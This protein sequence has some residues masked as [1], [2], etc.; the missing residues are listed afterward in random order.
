[1]SV[2]VDQKAGRLLAEGRVRLERVAGDLVV[3]TV[4]GDTGTYAVECAQASWRCNCPARSE[5]SHLLA[6]QLVVVPRYATPTKRELADACA[7]ELRLGMRGDD[8]PPPRP[9][10]LPLPL[11]TVGTPPRVVLDDCVMCG[12]YGPTTTAGTCPDCAQP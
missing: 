4:E 3:A 1:M 7:H 12:G 5:C 11:L 9:R 6:V 10:P 8:P 2:F